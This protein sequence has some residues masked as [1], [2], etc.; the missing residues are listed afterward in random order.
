[1]PFP[2]VA[3]QSAQRFGSKLRSTRSPPT[4]SMRSQFVI[5]RHAM[6]FSGSPRFSIVNRR[7]FVVMSDVP[8]DIAMTFVLPPSVPP[9]T[10]VASTEIS[11]LVTVV[12]RR[13]GCS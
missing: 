8:S 13:A 1:M 5:T 4:V 10:L 11:P 9:C 12:G 3:V 2:N 6:V 7:A